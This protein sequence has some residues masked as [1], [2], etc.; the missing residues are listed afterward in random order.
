[1]VEAQ[2]LA[3]PGLSEVRL[4]KW[5][6]AARFFKTRTLAARAIAQGRVEVNG[7]TAKASRDLHPGDRVSIREPAMG[8]REVEVLRLSDVRGPAPVAQSL[9]AE[10][11]QSQER[12]QQL[13][14][15]R[16]LGV[17]P[18]LSRQGGRP[19]KRERRALAPWQRWS[20]SLEPE[21]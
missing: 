8:Q 15:A 21:G 13:A 16:R 9:Y 12:R 5:L 7:T 19:T 18:A 10:T 4:D 11:V 3:P 14:Q 1:M 2:S 6:W 17:E 20:A